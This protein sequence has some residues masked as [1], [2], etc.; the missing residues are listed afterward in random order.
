MVTS[1]VS[2]NIENCRDNLNFRKWDC[3]GLYVSQEMWYWYNY[4]I[5]SGFVTCTEAVRTYMYWNST[6]KKNEKD[7]VSQELSESKRNG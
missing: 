7:M 1:D 2:D 5:Y 6:E 4:T 3:H